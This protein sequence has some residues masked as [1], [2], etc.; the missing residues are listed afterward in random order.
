MSE[1]TDQELSRWIA[2]AFGH[3]GHSPSGLCNSLYRSDD[4][5]CDFVNNPA[6]TVMLLEKMIAER[7]F[8]SLSAWISSPMRVCITGKI[9]NSGWR[10]DDPS[11]YAASD[12]LGR[13][14]AEAAALTLGWNHDLSR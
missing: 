14:V 4:C 9:E 12:K 8:V 6:A 2:K 13:A 1:L 5:T 7:G 10:S 11:T 3:V